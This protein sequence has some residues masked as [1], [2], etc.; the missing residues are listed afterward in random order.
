MKIDPVL[1]GGDGH[2]TSVLMLFNGTMR[3]FDSA[4]Q[5][6][7][8]PVSV[9]RSPY[10][11]PYAGWNETEDGHVDLYLNSAVPH[12]EQMTYQFAHE[13]CHALSNHRQ[14]RPPCFRW[15]EESMCEAASRYALA[16][17]KDRF[18]SYGPYLEEQDAVL[19][20]REPPR[21]FAS[22]FAEQYDE[23]RSFDWDDRSLP[24]EIRYRVRT[25]TL[26]IGKELYPLFVEFPKGWAIVRQLNK[27]DS[28]NQSADEF[29]AEWQSRLSPELAAFVGRIKA[30]L[31]GS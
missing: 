19:P 3:A 6:P 28:Q 8:R 24:A 14:T 15:F 25:V 20:P 12:F 29:F 13:F 31:F 27:W 16:A 7:T 23:L 10:N 5:E 26:H 21:D 18:P 22:W 2:L 30:T 17:Q 1:T 9:S 11:H 4:L